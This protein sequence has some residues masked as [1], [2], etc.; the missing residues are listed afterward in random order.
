MQAL[1]VAG[2]VALSDPAYSL[3]GVCTKPR[4]PRIGKVPAQFAH[5]SSLKQQSAQV[6]SSSQGCEPKGEQLSSLAMEPVSPLVRWSER[7]LD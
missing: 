2:S 4:L 7:L 6:R 5:H 3:Q 1:L